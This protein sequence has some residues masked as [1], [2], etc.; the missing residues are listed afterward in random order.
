M[1]KIL[2]TFF[3]L[4]VS[5]NSYTAK[6]EAEKTYTEDE[7]KKEVNKQVEAKLKKLNS[8]NIVNFST[9]LLKR[10]QDLELKE[11]EL[12]KKS[13]EIEMSSKDLESRVI[14]FQKKQTRFIGC[15]DNVDQQKKKRV[16]HMVDSIAGMKPTT[17]AEILSVQDSG[18][19][20]QILGRLS[21]EKVSKIFNSMN[22]EVSA[23]LQKQ[24]L[25]MQK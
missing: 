4:L 14:L 20:V 12:N 2:I 13:R 6:K 22:K 11:L 15:L 19:S 3:I 9:D 10:E 25:N 18:I 23:R 7:L 16:D 21:P 24:Y 8:K 5:F 17:A 1:K